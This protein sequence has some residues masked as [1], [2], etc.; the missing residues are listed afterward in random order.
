MHNV[1]NNWLRL[2]VSGKFHYS[3]FWHTWI[4]CS[5]DHI[6]SE[7]IWSYRLLPQAGPLPWC[8]LPQWAP[9]RC[10]SLRRSVAQ[11]KQSTLRS[12]T[13]RPGRLHP[14]AGWET[15]ASAKGNGNHHI[16]YY[17]AKSIQSI[18][19]NHLFKIKMWVDMHINNVGYCSDRKFCLRVMRNS[20]TWLQNWGISDVCLCNPSRQPDGQERTLACFYYA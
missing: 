19:H 1:T 20:Q 11:T 6:L 14:S 4:K 9:G 5:K 17:Y 2:K 15:E 3:T 12:R 16:Y 10:N 18:M 13:Q 7:G 8:C